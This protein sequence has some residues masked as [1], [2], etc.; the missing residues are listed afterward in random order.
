M[1]KCMITIAILL[2]SAIG[3][4]TT[5]RSEEKGLDVGLRK[6]KLFASAADRIN[7]FFK[8]L[9]E[10]ERQGIRSAVRMTK[11]GELGDLKKLIKQGDFMGEMSAL[12]YYDALK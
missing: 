6:G 1:S 11:Y 7:A 8:T 12:T 10:S 5:P 4:K 3:C 9:K 2:V